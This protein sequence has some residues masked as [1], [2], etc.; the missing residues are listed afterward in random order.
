[1]KRIVMLAC[2]AICIAMFAMCASGE[3]DARVLRLPA[4]ATHIG[5]EAFQADD[6]ITSVVIPRSVADVGAHAFEGCDALVQI[7]VEEGAAVTFEAEAFANCRS[8]RQLVVGSGAELTLGS[9]AFANAANGFTLMVSEGANIRFASDALDDMNGVTFYAHSGSAVELYALSHGYKTVSLDSE[10]S[11]EHA[12]QLIAAYGVLPSNLQGS[13]IF[14]TKRLIIVTDEQHLPDISAWNPVQIVR[15]GDHTYYAQFAE[16]KDAADCYN[17]LYGNVELVEP[18]M[19]LASNINYYDEVPYSMSAAAIT[20]EQSWGTDDPI[21]FDVYADYVS[22][23]RNDN[24][25]SVVAVI[26]SGIARGRGYDRLLTDGINL[27][28]DRGMNEWYNVRNYHGSIIAS[29][30]EACVGN[31]DVR[32]MPIRIEESTGAIDTILLSHAIDYAVAHGAHIINLSF[33]LDKSSEYLTMTIRNAID[34]GVTVVAAAGNTSKPVSEVYPAS[35]EG[36]KAVAGIAPGNRLSNA[37]GFGEGISYGAP[38]IDISHTIYNILSNGTSFAAP[39]I[40]AALALVRLDANHTI[41]DLNQSCLFIDG[42]GIGMPLLNR[43]ANVPTSQVKFDDDTPDIIAVGDHIRL[44][45]TVLPAKATDKSVTIRSSNTSIASVTVDENGAIWLD[46][47]KSGWTQLNLKANDGNSPEVNRIIA[48]TQPVTHVAISG[49][50]HLA[51]MHGD[52]IQL[53]AEVG[54]EDA[55]DTGIIWSTT[56]ASVVAV[57]DQG[58]VSIGNAGKASIIATAKDG[59]GESDSWEITVLNNPDAETIT[60][61][62]GDSN[63]DGTVVM[64]DTLPLDAVV[65]PV[66]SDQ[67]VLWSVVPGTGKATMQGNVLNPVEPGTVTVFAFSRSNTDLSSFI[68]VNIIA[69][70]TEIVMDTGDLEMWIGDTRQM[71]CGFG[72]EGSYMP[73]ITWYSSNES[74]LSIDPETGM[75]TAISTGE[76][77][78]HAEADTRIAN[79][80]VIPNGETLISGQRK[81]VVYPTPHIFFDYNGGIS[82]VTEIPSRYGVAVGQLPTASRDNYDFLG[83]YTD[84]S[85]GTEYTADTIVDRTDSFTLYAH[86][87]LKL[88]TVTF[89]ANGGQVNTPSMT[90][91]VNTPL[92]TLPVPTRDYYTFNGWYTSA[93]GGTWIYSGTTFATAAPVTLYAHWNIN[94]YNEWSSWT[95]TPYY[96]SNTRQVETE[97]RVTY[98]YK[99]VYHYERFRYWNTNYGKW[100]NTFV[101]VSGN[102]YCGSGSWQ[103]W[104]STTRLNA[105]WVSE[106]N[107]Y[108]Y[109]GTTSYEAGDWFNE[110]TSQDVDQTIHTTWYRYRDRKR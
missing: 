77:Y 106:Y 108:F 75:V 9:G 41:E 86:W 96:S 56:D 68:N 26:D 25:P 24:S 28:S 12:R 59:Y 21:G 79:G 14:E 78:I 93:V 76:A 52:D 83:W 70:P 54:P 92:G 38:S 99:T 72:P 57:D 15:N 37:T 19:I 33:K 102:S 67:G 105:R 31:N 51:Y 95:T 101:D 4:A 3:E 69:A 40:C 82:N 11:L 30:I 98:T 27:A 17:A 71:T 44:G 16:D 85:D 64:G 63:T 18:D 84:P 100:Y 58:K 5:E 8:L 80:K 29:I 110:W 90:A 104:A 36:V 7:S 43:L 39:Q 46:A 1:M 53:S 32:I 2:I 35:I 34:A 65:G 61:L 89:N 6:S 55:N 91:T 107:R 13:S 74:V 66:G 87:Q 94:D 47:L 48:V 22:E 103:Y 20:S 49:S 23:N 62:G 81:V 73:S 45:W 10:D 50:T 60:I 42:A 88:F 97:D 109:S